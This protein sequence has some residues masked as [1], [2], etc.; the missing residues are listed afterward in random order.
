[1]LQDEIA[2]LQKRIKEDKLMAKK[3]ANMHK[4]ALDENK[5]LIKENSNLS[6]E[7]GKLEM[8]IQQQ[9]C[10]PY[11][12]SLPAAKVNKAFKFMS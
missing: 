4:Q 2:A 9:N 11:S 8:I 12:R 6:S 1:M 10:K 7:I 3:D 5:A